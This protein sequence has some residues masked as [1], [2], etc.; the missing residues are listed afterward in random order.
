M[1]RG[2][3]LSNI[4]MAVFLNLCARLNMSA[5]TRRMDKPLINILLA[6][7]R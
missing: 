4:L 1:Y 2:L 3:G 6:K 7:F 5:R